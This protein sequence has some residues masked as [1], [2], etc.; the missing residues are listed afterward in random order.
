MN[1]RLS[2]Q[3]N[4]S[5]TR[6]AHQTQFTLPLRLSSQATGSST[7]SWR[8][9]EM[10]RLN[11]PLP[12]AWNTDDSTTPMPASRKCSEM[13]RSAGTPMASMASLAAK[14]PST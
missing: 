14:M 7:A 6:K 13:V 1:A 10:I 2:T 11:T 8:Q 5:A 3:L 9:I 4:T 12:S